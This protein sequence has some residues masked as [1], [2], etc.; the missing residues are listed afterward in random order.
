LKKRGGPVRL[1]QTFELDED[2]ELPGVVMCYVSVGNWPAAG[3][4]IA[5]KEELTTDFNL[6][7]TSGVDVLSVTLPEAGY[8]VISAD[9]AWSCSSA[10]GGT[11]FAAI[12]REDNYYLG[13]VFPSG[14]G[15]PYRPS[16]ARAT[17]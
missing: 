13:P 6:T 17:R 5:G 7:G 8:Y 2:D 4:V 9:V 1:L 14:I 12:R 15:S 11:I 10:S 3:T 16:D